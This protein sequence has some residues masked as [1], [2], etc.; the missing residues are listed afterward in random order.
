MKKLLALVV[1]F[2][3][4]FAAIFGQHPDIVKGIWVSDGKDAKV[5]IYKAGD[6]YFGR[7]VWTKNMYEAD[8]K[9]LK[10]DIKNSNKKLQDRTILNLVVLSGLTYNNGEWSG[11]EIYDPKSGK[12]YKSRVKVKGNSLEVRGF[13]GAPMFGRTT[14]WTR[15]S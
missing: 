6:K 15:V 9:T 3:T 14:T 12:T 11:G 10:K 5:E 1:F 2:I 13:I 4:S 8:G 7:I